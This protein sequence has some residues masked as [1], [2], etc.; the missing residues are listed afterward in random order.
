[1]PVDIGRR[2]ALAGGLALGAAGLLARPTPAQAATM[3]LNV[4]YDPTRELYAEIDRAFMADWA[5]AHGG[6]VVMVRT[7]NGGSGAQARS[8]LDGAPADVVT[9][10]LGYDIAMLA[11][12]GLLAHDW[13]QRLPHQSTPFS[14]TIVFLV[15]HGNPK[16][17]RDWGDLIRSD[18]SVVTPNPK[19]SGGARWNFLAAWGWAARQPGASAQSAQDYM[20][21]L[22]ARVPVLDT[23]ARGA[24]NSFVQRGMGDV[25]IAWEDEA[26][27]AVRDIGN[28]AFDLV[29]PSISVLAEPPV[30]VV[31]RNVQAHGTQ[32]QAEGFVRF[33]YTPAAQEIGAKHYFR[34]SDQA[35]AARHADVLPPIDTFD[36]SSFGGWSAAQAKFFADGGVFDQIYT[37]H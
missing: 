12:H 6:E 15:R 1:M 33:L 17:I 10:G 19:T 14:S 23:G 36:I 25:L 31:D 20:K 7:S 26:L 34:P 30:A 2:G 22:F 35:V 37:P 28:G 13:Q 32:A 9:L 3:L 11:A 8:V 29:R 18:V 24:T 5:R 21:A 16:K 4:S 27:L